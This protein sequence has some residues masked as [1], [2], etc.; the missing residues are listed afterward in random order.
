MRST[1]SGSP[2]AGGPDDDGP[3]QCRWL[4]CAQVFDSA[5]SLF[6]H[7]CEAHVGRKAAGTLCLKCQWTDEHSGVVCNVEK[8][9]SPSLVV[10]KRSGTMKNA[11]N[12]SARKPQPSA[13]I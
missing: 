8:G 3:H 11:N 5:D 1:T 13:T 9:A 10:A 6:A 12:D 4:P 7:V 2:Q